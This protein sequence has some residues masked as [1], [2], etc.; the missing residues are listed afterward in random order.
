MA[1]ADLGSWFAPVGIFQGFARMFLL[2]YGSAICCIS[3]Y[4]LFPSITVSSQQ[5]SG[6]GATDTRIQF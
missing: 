6:R 1:S 2:D 3:P 4:P 5:V